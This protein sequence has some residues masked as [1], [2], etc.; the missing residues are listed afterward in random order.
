MAVRSREELISGLK[1]IIGESTDDTTIG[2]VEDLTDTLSDYDGRIAESGDWRSKYEENDAMWRQKYTERF[3]SEPAAENAGT[4]IPPGAYA[5]NG[6]Q[7]NGTI[8]TDEGA[9]VEKGYDITLDDL[10]T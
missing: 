9:E 1:S 7:E 3:F 10:F 8:A 2:F 4:G 6:Y 5:S